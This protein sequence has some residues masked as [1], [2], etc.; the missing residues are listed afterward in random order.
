MRHT[1]RE[2]VIFLLL[3]PVVLFLYWMGL[4]A[5]NAPEF[6]PY[7]VVP[8]CKNI[9]EHGPW[10]K[11]Q[12][13]ERRTTATEIVPCGMEGQPVTTTVTHLAICC[14]DGVIYVM[15]DDNTWLRFRSSTSVGSL[16]RTASN[17]PLSDYLH[18]K[19]A[20][21]PFDIDACGMKGCNSHGR[22]DADL[23]LVRFPALIYGWI[24][25]LLI[26]VGYR[27]IRFAVKG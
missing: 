20:L 14:N 16:D 1:A 24:F 2:A 11:Y 26:W 5:Y 3:G 23:G 8:V 9:A 27:L 18:P 22:Y 4:E 17:T 21:V 19:Y 7:Q 6:A 12:D 13:P 15:K 25:G 10:E